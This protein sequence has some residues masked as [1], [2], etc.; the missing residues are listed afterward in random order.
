MEKAINTPFLLSCRK[1]QSNPIPKRVTSK[2]I[3]PIL[4]PERSEKA[5]DTTSQPWSPNVGG[6]DVLTINSST[7]TTM[8]GRVRRI[9]VIIDHMKLFPFFHRSSFWKPQL[10]KNH[11]MRTPNTI[12]E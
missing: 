7:V 3:A 2:M 4:N 10:K 1:A 5:R 6:D 11:A 9:K 12:I 8:R